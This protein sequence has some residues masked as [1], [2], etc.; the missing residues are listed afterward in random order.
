MTGHSARAR[1]TMSGSIRAA[2]ASTAKRR[3]ESTEPIY[4][5]VTLNM[6]NATNVGQLLS[7]GGAMIKVTNSINH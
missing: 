3:G 7:A 5:T 2:A 6:F 4:P 1:Q